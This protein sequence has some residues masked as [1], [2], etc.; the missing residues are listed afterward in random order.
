MEKVG[1]VEWYYCL[2]STRPD[3]CSPPT[4]D[5]VQEKFALVR[6]GDIGDGKKCH[7]NCQKRCQ[8]ADIEYPINVGKNYKLAIL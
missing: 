5:L 3:K 2:P 1:L 7:M 6:G 8:D 4:W